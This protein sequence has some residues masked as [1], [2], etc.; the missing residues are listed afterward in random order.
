MKRLR[1][2]LVAVVVTLIFNAPAFAGPEW[3]FSSRFRALA[4]TG[5]AAFNP[6]GLSPMLENIAC[7][8]AAPQYNVLLE[9]NGSVSY[10]YSNDTDEFENDIDYHKLFA[11]SSSGLKVTLPFLQTSDEDDFTERLGIHLMPGLHATYNYFKD[12]YSSDEWERNAS[13]TR[14]QFFLR[15]GAAYGINKYLAMGLGLN[16]IMPTLIYHNQSGEVPIWDITTISDDEDTTN[17]DTKDNY[18]T[19]SPF[20]FSPEIG[21]LIRPIEFLQIGITYEN[22]DLQA[23]RPVVTHTKAEKDENYRTDAISARS[24]SFGLGLAAMI[25]DIHMLMVSTDLDVEWRRGNSTDYGYYADNQKIQWSFGVEKMWEIASIKGGLGYAD[26]AGSKR[27]LPYDRFF[28]SFG[29]D[30]FLDEHVMMG[31]AFNG[32][33]GY[34]KSQPKSG[35]AFGG[36]GAY[37]FGGTF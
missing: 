32:D 2:F 17:Y 28:L 36:G 30:I 15:I 37:T 23:R 29:T 31:I 25:P 34:R 1:F 22:G 33:I 9:G 11:S 35:L 4:E 3:E 20:M 10:S 16:F 12:T 18:F 26:E 14:A 24:P 19:Y 6:R 21:F 5:N 7:L 27:Y 8:A 13:D